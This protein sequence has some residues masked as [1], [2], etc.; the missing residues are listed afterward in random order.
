MRHL[1]AYNFWNKRDMLHLAMAG[2]LTTYNMEEDTIVFVLDGCTDDS[3]SVFKNIV[4]KMLF[5]WDV[6]CIISNKEQ[7]EIQHTI[8][9]QK[10]CLD[11]NFDSLHFF[12][13][14]TLITGVSFRRDVEIVMNEY[15]NSLGVIGGRDGFMDRYTGRVSSYWST[16]IHPAMEYEGHLVS[17]DDGIKILPPGKYEEVLFVNNGPIVYPRDTIDKMGYLDERF[18][19]HYFDEDY[20]FRCGS[21]GLKNILLGTEMCHVKLGRL[22]ASKIYDDRYKVIDSTT[23]RRKWECI[24][25]QQ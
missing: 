15:G 13:D 1:V 4:G 23:L 7:Y 24:G 11:E 8:I 6:R 20:C 25:Y 3:L 5:G 14:D 2:I 21:N 19:F 9:L 17:K 12:H 18:F 22:T 16:T 10:M